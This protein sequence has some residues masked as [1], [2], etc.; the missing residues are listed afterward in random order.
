MSDVFEPQLD[1][2]IPGMSL[3]HEVGAR[4]WQNPP[5]YSTVEDT[6][7]FYLSRVGDEKLLYNILS[8]V[9]NGVAIPTIAE[10]LTLSGV[11]E[12]KHTVDVGVI[13]NP[14]IT[15]FIKGLADRAGVSYTMDAQR[16]YTD[17]D[18]TEADL[19]KAEKEI[20]E[21][22]SIN[23]ENVEELMSDITNKVESEEPTGL[24]ARPKQDE[25][26]E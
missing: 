5:Q 7:E 24:M 17:M 12:G 13:V 20:I 26:Q 21:S 6:L 16:D 1:A 18:I 11:M 19:D 15:E 10:T 25:E 3:T 9:E 8:V 2:P 23:K 14:I 22:N 4:P